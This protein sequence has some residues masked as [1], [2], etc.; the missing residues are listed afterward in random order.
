MLPPPGSP[1]ASWGTYRASLY[2]VFRG[3]DPRVCLAF[4]LFGL[5]NNVLYVIIL[6]AALDLVGPAVPKG[7]V[8]LAD[9]LPGFF[10]KLVAPYFIHTIPYSVR[11]FIFVTLSACGMLLIATTPA[12]AEGG[13]IN[14]K[15]AGVVL[16]S[17]SSGAGEMSFL[18]LTHYYGQFSLAAWGSGTGGAGLVGA[19]AYVAATTWFGWSVK[20]SLLAFSFLPLILL[21]S[22]FVVLPRGPLKHTDRESQY[23]TVSAE[24]DVDGSTTSH[25]HFEDST[26]ADEEGLLSQTASHK[27]SNTDLRLNRSVSGSLKIAWL[28]F[29]S[30]LRRTRHLFV[31]YMLPL[32]LVYVAEYTIN[33]GVAPTLLFPLASSPFAHFRAFY[34]TYNA[35]YQVGVFIS[36]SST[37]FFRVHHLYFPS[38]LQCLNLALLILHALYDFIPSVYWVFLVVFWEGLLGGLVYVNTFAEITDRVHPQ[39]REFSLGATSVSD[40]AGICIAGFVGMAVE[41]WLCDWQVQRGRDYCRK[42]SQKTV[43]PK[44]PRITPVQD[45]MEGVETHGSTSSDVPAFD[46]AQRDKAHQTIRQNWSI[47][48]VLMAIPAKDGLRPTK[49]DDIDGSLMA[50]IAEVSRN[51]DLPRARELMIKARDRRI[52]ELVNSGQTLLTINDRER[53][54]IASDV[55][56][57]LFDDQ[58]R[59]ASP[60]KRMRIGEPPSERTEHA[61]ESKTD[62]AGE[63]KR[64]RGREVLADVT[65]DES[66]ADEQDVKRALLQAGGSEPVDSATRRGY[67]EY[68]PGPSPLV[69]NDY[70]RPVL[71]R[72]HAIGGS[73][74]R[75]GPSSAGAGERQRLETP[76][77]TED[78][79]TTASSKSTVPIPLSTDIGNHK[80][81]GRPRAS[82]RTTP[83]ATPR[84]ASP[85]TTPKKGPAHKSTS[86]HVLPPHVQDRILPLLE[87]DP[88]ADLPAADRK[89]MTPTLMID[90]QGDQRK[91]GVGL[92]R[93]V[94][95][96]QSHMLKKYLK[97][98]V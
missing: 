77:F 63:R 68:R 18:G 45:K 22:F 76:S 7:V 4:W 17:L 60:A 56:D 26:H 31:P 90:K 84:I 39:D 82:S 69:R 88:T 71:P 78:G 29:Q 23:Q 28:G 14:T 34:P 19:G 93:Y 96:F 38:F 73:S 9:V 24:E 97:R 95:D 75:P 40:S 81:S 65:K 91:F 52:L 41:V 47:S 85:N 32:L 6:S 36:R 49:Q 74:Y 25:S 1:A 80:G 16:A 46:L 55:W 42:L 48:N 51:F 37:P 12:F 83:S 13:S 70:Y 15:M 58:S 3:A 94:E 57:I 50:S 66:D 2:N 11:I 61:S 59:N 53:K 92:V 54:L 8:L 27:G 87:W 44:A 79:D 89:T 35:I 67:D 21:L 64:K 86:A 43:Q 10:T 5:I 33:Q 62:K 98:R 72:P 20:R 30:N